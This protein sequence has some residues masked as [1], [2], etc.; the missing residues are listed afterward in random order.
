M[1]YKHF[2]GYRRGEN[3]ELEIV[4]EEA[5]AVRKIYQLFLEAKTPFGIAQALMTAG[6]PS[7]AGKTKWSTS[8]VLS[9]LTNEKYKGVSC[10]Y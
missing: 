6:I 8:T 3:G 10:N 4:E 9:I 7:P 1:P 2:L 5:A